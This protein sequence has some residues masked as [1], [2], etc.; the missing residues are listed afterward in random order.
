MVGAWRDAQ[1]I[2]VQPT[3]EVRV[4]IQEALAVWTSD[5]Q[6]QEGSEDPAT[7]ELPRD[8]GVLLWDRP[9]VVVDRA[10]QVAADIEGARDLRRVIR[11]VVGLL[12][13]SLRQGHGLQ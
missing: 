1:V 2:H 13:R 5:V 10:G 11:A 6:G 4:D 8:V 9:S 7:V 12:L 3:L